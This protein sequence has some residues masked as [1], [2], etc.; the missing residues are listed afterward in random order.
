LPDGVADLYIQQDKVPTVFAQDLPEA[1]AQWMAATQRPV[2]DAALNEASSEPAWKTIPSW[3]IY[4]SVDLVIPPAL[5][6]FMAERADA[7]ETVVI[8]GGSHVAMIS[9]PDEVA[10]IINRVATEVALHFDA[11]G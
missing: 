8:E 9:H 7:W 10:H 1:D 4:G 6:A 3:F 5:I 11:A 2:T